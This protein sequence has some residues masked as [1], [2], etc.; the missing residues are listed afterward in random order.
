MRQR[1]ARSPDPRKKILL[2][3][4][5]TRLCARRSR[6]PGLFQLSRNYCPSALRSLVNIFPFMPWFLAKGSQRSG[7]LHGRA[8]THWLKIITH[9]L[10][11]GHLPATRCPS[12]LRYSPPF[13]FLV[14]LFFFLADTSSSYLSRP[15]SPRKLNKPRPLS[16]QSRKLGRRIKS[17]SFPP[18]PPPL[19]SY[20]GWKFRFVVR[21]TYGNQK[22]T[23]APAKYSWHARYGASSSRG[24]RNFFFFYSIPVF[25]W[26]GTCT[27]QNSVALILI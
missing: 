24:F 14:L 2:K 5:V 26:V 3:I 20:V 23:T 12:F 4:R 25:V 22:R 8:T 27:W 6:T 15:R 18:P 19:L 11:R 17:Y 1:R 21:D 16:L 7:F 10:Q 13:S 9:R